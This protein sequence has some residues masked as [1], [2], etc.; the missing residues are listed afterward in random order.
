MDAAYRDRPYV[1]DPDEAELLVRNVRV[2]SRIWAAAQAFFFMAFLFAF[3]YL[4]ALN[5]NGTV[6]ISGH[7]LILR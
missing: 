5:S 2:G 1:A 7:G 6:I 3:F 4:R